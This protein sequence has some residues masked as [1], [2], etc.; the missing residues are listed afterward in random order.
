M[1]NKYFNRFLVAYDFLLNGEVQPNATDFSDKKL[2]WQGYM[3]GSISSLNYVPTYLSDLDEYKDYKFL[4]FINPYSSFHRGFSDFNSDFIPGSI[5]NPTLKKLINDKR[6]YLIIYYPN[7]GWVDYKSLQYIHSW[8][9]NEGIDLNRM[10]LINS[11][12]KIKK[13]YDEFREKSRMK[14]EL[15]VLPH[16]WALDDVPTEYISAAGDENQSMNMEY[17]VEHKK[18]DFNF[19]NRANRRH[20]FLMILNLYKE[21]LVKNNLVSYDLNFD[22]SEFSGNETIYEKRRCDIQDF[23]N[24]YDDDSEYESMLSLYNELYETLPKKVVD[25][26]DKKSI[27]GLQM[28][29]DIP[30]KDSMFTIV[31]ESYFSENQNIG[32]ISEKVFKPIAHHHPFIIIGVPGLL[33]YLRELG[34]K[35]FEPYINES[36][37]LEYNYHKR[38]FLILDEIK[39]LCNLSDTEKMEWMKGVLPIINHN[40][41]NLKRIEKENPN[42]D[43]VDKIASVILN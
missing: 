5:P 7:E 22:D 32:Y 29:T 2:V 23:H 34:F 37:D 4:Y 30:Y 41:E 27:F 31:G 38:F 15:H 18:Y 43:V 35:T 24:Y 8:F 40:Y 17:K 12:F 42:I 11:N 19:L 25:F 1:E 13:W 26:E 14:S 6:F 28:E 9:K 21:N 3:H 39:R 16:H 20:R 36:Y 33:K 10:I